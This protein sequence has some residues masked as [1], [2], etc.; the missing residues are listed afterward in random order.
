MTRAP[1]SNNG[2]DP[3]EIKGTF[4]ILGADGTPQIGVV[5]T[6]IDEFGETCEDPNEAVEVVGFIHQ[7]TE[8]GLWVRFEN[9]PDEWTYHRVH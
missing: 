8:A 9:E 1:Q 7:G 3:A 6:W 2:P 5:T 4:Q